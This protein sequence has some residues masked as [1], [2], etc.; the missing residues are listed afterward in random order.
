MG[1]QISEEVTMF[2]KTMV[3]GLLAAV[4]AT[5]VFASAASK[6]E[7]AGV[8]AGAVIGGV[9]GGPA[10]AI[11]GA[12][13]GAKFGDEFHQRNEAIDS[14][15]SSLNASDNQ[16][17]A[18]QRN[19]DALNGEIRSIDGELQ[20]A[21]E[22]SKPEVLALLQAGIEMDLLFR[23]DEDVLAESTGGKVSQLAAS[24]AG[25]P[26]IQVRL[27]GFADERGDETYNQELSARRVEHVRDV[28]IK[29]GI[30]ASSITVSAHGES[31]AIDQSIDS[32]ALER[33]VS[34]T[35]Y[36]GDTPSFASNPR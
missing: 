17:V 22:L 32:Y 5:P 31:P 13:I 26:E 35:L 3:F 19:I 2:R 6:A 8:G 9:V 4:I 36:I 34:L 21:R 18:L 23:T 16:L 28:L 14:L 20:Q 25:N 7:S 15:T 27:D 1:H 12:A 11:I 29:N 30:P 24:I 10:G 33:R